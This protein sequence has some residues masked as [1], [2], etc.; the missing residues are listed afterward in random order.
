[1][2]D[3]RWEQIKTIVDKALTLSGSEKDWYMST[4]CRENPEI[5]AEVEELLHSIEESEEHRFMNPIHQ[6]HKELVSDLADE[7]ESIT[8]EKE[9]IGI[10]I[11]A[12]RI[13]EVLGSGGMGR[14]FKAE[15]TD[16]E[17]HQTVAV[18]LIKKGA[19]SRE[20]IRRFMMEREILAGL[21][22]PDIAQLYDGGV[23]ADGVPYLI[24]E[25]IEGVPI[26]RYCNENQ[27]TLKQRLHIFSKVCS[28][29]Q[30]AHA[31]LVV[32]R[33]L[34]AQNISVTS[35]GV[36]KILDFGIAK[37]LNPQRIDIPLLE[38]RPGQKF[39]TPQYAAPELIQ[40]DPVTI[41][42]DV[43]SLGVLLHYLL[44]DTYPLSFE[45][46][47]IQGIE[48]TITEAAPV[49]PGQCFSNHPKKNECA[50]QRKTTAANLQKEL[51]GDLDAIVLK[52]LR[53]EP[54]ARYESVTGLT[55][56]IHRL[57]SGQP[58]LAR[59][60]SVTY[61]A[62][63]FMHRHRF[64][65]M[66]VAV[67]F[68]ALSFGLAGTLWQ[69]GIA[70]EQAAFANRT[71]NFV[72]SLFQ[73]MSPV[74]GSEG[75]ALTAL[76]LLKR[77]AERVESELDDAP[78]SQ[79][80][81]RIAF[82]K[83]LFEMGEPALAQPLVE[84]GI[85]QLRGLYDEE[86]SPTLALGLYELSRIYMRTGSIAEA[87]SAIRE[88]LAMLNRI[89]EEPEL[90]RIRLRDLLAQIANSN[91]RFEEAFE[92]YNQNLVDRTAVLGENDSGLAS[93]WYNLGSTAIQ[94]QRFVE[95]GEAYLRVED[96]LLARADSLHPR[97]VDFHLGL[98]AAFTGQGMY[99]EADI[100][101]QRA[102]DLAHQLQGV[103]HPLRANILNW[104][105]EI[106]RHEGR[107]EEA[108]ELRKEAVEFATVAGYRSQLGIYE[109]GLGL[110]FL[111]AGDFQSA[112][113]MLTMAERNIAEYRSVNTPRHRLSQ[114]ALGFARFRT[115]AI[116][117]GE[118]EIRSALDAMHHDGQ[119]QRL[120]YAE[121]AA[122]Y[123]Q[124][125]DER[126]A[127][128]ASEEWQQQ[129]YSVYE[130][131]LGAGHPRTQA[132]ASAVAIKSTPYE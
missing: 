15:R 64:G 115:G 40:G 65:V 81:L 101:L 128:A 80:E 90:L 36:V 17:F 63:K 52:T 87:E 73:E 70:K 43:Y 125:L 30:F 121:S 82:G 14:V 45:G 3:P 117:I 21:N 72:I 94:A 98:G 11:G 75:M 106:R 54:E 102:L 26:D 20:N 57:L 109:L 9:F 105:G 69:A 32:H 112:I 114:S 28:A 35:D 49:P 108:R 89:D 16:G 78:A 62:R 79:A 5:C 10:E 132:V 93:A 74:R 124:L 122:L 38:T 96:L 71:K 12:Y 1:M 47:T 68:L 46:K 66:S 116:E 127:Y 59:H 33:D 19:D 110:V 113:E 103:R 56:D 2:K 27:L 34:K 67:V 83:L 41:A 18:K 92:L 23:T 129:A 86:S 48:K 88:S 50:A 95:A 84:R 8:S 85:E 107:L 4:I 77:S 44:T 91:N 25:F 51:K 58:V 130:K 60:G 119:A 76:D 22:H 123:A 29:V 131:I 13:T 39:W 126:G 53:K 55:D 120:E 97:R 99:A 100:E 6:E 7:L 118:S 104:M 61:R 42:A 24:M 31:N 111:D 37:L